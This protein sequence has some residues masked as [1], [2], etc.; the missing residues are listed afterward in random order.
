MEEKNR[1][2]FVGFIIICIVVISMCMFF[3]CSTT[4]EQVNYYLLE[5]LEEFDKDKSPVVH[6]TILLKLLN[7][8]DFCD[9]DWF[10]QVRSLIRIMEIQVDDYAHTED[11]YIQQLMKKQQRLIK[12]LKVIESKYPAVHAETKDVDELEAAYDDYHD[13]YYQKGGVV[14]EKN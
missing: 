11:E 8:V 10:K 4:D 7:T 1:R 6:M 3:S 12:A 14:N 5:D 9:E 13:Y 2:L